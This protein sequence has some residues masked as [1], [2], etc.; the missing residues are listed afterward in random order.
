MKTII[1]LDEKGNLDLDFY[2]EVG[3]VFDK[4]RLRTRVNLKEKDYI[5]SKIIKNS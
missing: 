1:E 3:L 2:I 5:K 4:H